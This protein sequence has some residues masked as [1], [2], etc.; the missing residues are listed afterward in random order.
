[1]ALSRQGVSHKAV[2][3]ITMQLLKPRGLLHL[4]FFRHNPSYGSFEGKAFGEK[5]LYKWWKRACR[6]LGIEG[7]DLYGGTRDSSARGL[8]L[9]R[10]PEEIKRATMHSTNKAFE[11]YFQFESDD[12]RSI[13]A[14][15]AEK[16]KTEI[17]TA[18]TPQKTGLEKGNLLKLQG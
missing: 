8:R 11:R 17:D 5:Y 7:V 14:D 16:R 3:S 9:H 1:M 13:Y 18:L 10:T 2:P 12:L 6:N 15:T 4:H